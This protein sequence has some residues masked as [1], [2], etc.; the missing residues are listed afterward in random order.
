MYDVPLIDLE[1]LVEDVREREAH[2]LT[3]QERELPCNLDCG[4]LLRVRIVRLADQEHILLFTLHHIISDGWSNEIFLREWTVL[5]QAFVADQVSPLAPLLV[6]YADFALWQ[7]QWLQG[8]ALGRQLAYWKEQ[9]AD[10]PPLEIPTDYPRPP[11]KTYS[12]ASRRI[13]LLSRL[14]EGLQ[15]LVVA[16]T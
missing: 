2:R 7:R 3:G 6:H 16:R 10:A 9:L 13:S 1:G 14:Q 12:G 4:P 8:E 5:Y 11:L 15:N